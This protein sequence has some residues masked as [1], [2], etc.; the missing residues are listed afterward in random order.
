MD[1]SVYLS[2]LRAKGY[3][4][5]KVG[6]VW[7]HT[8]LTPGLWGGRDRWISGLAGFRGRGKPFSEFEVSWGWY[9]RSCLQEKEEEK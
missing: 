3:Q 8:P 2:K 6:L 7:W 1:V 9:M 5:E 4:E